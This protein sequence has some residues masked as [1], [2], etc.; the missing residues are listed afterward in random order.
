MTTASAQQY[1]S[2]REF[3]IL[4][5]RYKWFIIVITGIF[6]AASVAIVLTIPNQY[7]AEMLVSPSEEQ[8][9]G[10][11]AALA[12][13]FGSLASLAGINLGGKGGDQM[14]LALEI[15]KSRQF[16]MGFI[17]KHE[18][19][20]PLMAAEKWDHNSGE[21]IINPKL[22]D[23]NSK[24]WVRDVQPPLR[25]EPT[26][27]EAYEA[28]RERLVVDRDAKSS[29]ITITFE[30]FSPHIAQQWLTLLVKDLNGYM[31]DIE[32]KESQRSVEYLQTQIANTEVA[33]LKNVFF[34]LIQEQL[35][36]AMLAEVREEFVFKTIDVAIV[37]E[38]KSKPSRAVICIIITMLGGLFSLFLVHLRQA[39]MGRKMIEA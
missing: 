6:A 4:S 12:N 27:F 28:F 34:Q 11:L 9:G 38:K 29:V 23:T 35:K 31:R 25:P 37:P 17:E 8:S 22:Y 16:L 14:L 39:L 24:K 10:G 32:L 36:K 1:F 3:I 13:Q 20:V 7:K 19:L 21:L 33:E 5:W 30:Y 2:L 26:L 18:L 15:F